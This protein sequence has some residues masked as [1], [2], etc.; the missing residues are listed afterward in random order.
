[1]G[2]KKIIIDQNNIAKDSDGI[3]AGSIKLLGEIA[4]K[5]IDSTKVTFEDFIK[6][7]AINPLNLLQINNKN[8][9]KDGKKVS[10]TIWDKGTLEPTKTFIEGV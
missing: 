1:M 4:V 5:I 9:L 6:F 2:G 3:L 8:Y 10:F 7:T